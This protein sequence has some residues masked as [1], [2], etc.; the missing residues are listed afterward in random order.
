MEIHVTVNDQPL[1]WQVNPGELL[2]DVLRREGYLSVKWGCGEGDCGACTI[3]VDGHSM[4]SCLMLVGQVEGR[5]LTTVESLGTVEQPH[6][7]QAAFVE[8]GAVQCGYCTPGML[9]SAKALI[10]QGHVPTEEQVRE[11]LDG[12][13]CRCTGYKKI[14]EAVLDAAERMNK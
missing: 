1:T 4:R 6:P 2:L 7:L 14:I 13:L 8:H 11:A 9:L 12:N 10:D 5:S 3:L